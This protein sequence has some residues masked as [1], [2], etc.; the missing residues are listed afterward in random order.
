MG[1]YN[2]V[3]LIRGEHQP[4]SRTILFL[5]HYD[6]VDTSEYKDLED[7]ACEPE[8]LAR[9]LAERSLPPEVRKD[10]ESGEWL[11]GRGV[12]DMKAGVAV[13]ME[14][15]R[16][17]SEQASELSGNVVF[18]A[19]GDEEAD[20][21]GMLS[22]AKP[23][24][25]LAK[26]HGLELTGAINT[27]VVTQMEADEPDTRY[28]YLGSM[29]KIVPAV[30]VVG[31]SAHVGESLRG[32]DAN[33]LL[34]R[35]TWRISGN[36]ELSDKWKDRITHPPVSLKQTDLKESYAGEVPFE[37][38]AYYNFL[39]YRRGPK[40]VIDSLVR[41]ATAAFQDCMNKRERALQRYIDATEQALE[42]DKPELKVM[43]YGELLKKALES[44][45]QETVDNLFAE[46][47]QQLRQEGVTDLRAQSLRFVRNLW[48]LSRLSG[49]AVVIFLAPPYYPPNDSQIEDEGFKSF[50]R[51]VTKCIASLQETV[52]YKLE[53]Q[54]YFPFL[55]DASFCAYTEGEENRT[56]LEE[57]MPCWSRGWEIDIENV[58][59]MQMPVIDMG[60]HGKDFHKYLE[61]VHVPYS[62]HYLPELI[63]QT[64]KHLLRSDACK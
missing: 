62:M 6:T 9:E 53:V 1:R 23:L 48:Q 19:V 13:L 31:R 34:S 12:A 32:V 11:F 56:A 43:T 28:L 35:I 40:K 41:E 37:G 60:V 21:Q 5:G 18:L 8:A 39:S 38:F 24:V 63:F 57:N 16:E 49:P 58:S 26:E 54:D 15:F 45:D 4:Q 36:M 51:E 25:D 22:A 44:S 2:V 30:Y 55:S 29:G 46:T 7:V 64:T 14:V 50:N 47:Q 20:S 3:A 59:Q 52:P 10:L 33:D 17:L 61:R 27:D 42:P